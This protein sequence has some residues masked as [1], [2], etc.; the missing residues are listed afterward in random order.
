GRASRILV[1]APASV[2]KQWQVE[3]REKFNLNWPIYDGHML[4]WQATPMQPEGRELPVLRTDWHRQP[5]VIVSSHLL[6][7]QDRFD[8]VVNQAEPWD[9]VVLDEAH[10]ARRKSAANLAEER[11]NALLRLMRDLA[12]RTPGLVLLTATPMQVH[13]VEVWDL[14]ALLGLP[15][16]WHARAFLDFFEQ[17]QHPNPSHETLDQ[18]ARLF[19]AAE[20]RFGSLDPA[21]V[22]RRLEDV[23]VIRLR[24]VLDALRS[25]AGIP[26]RMLSVD[27]RQLALRLARLA[28]PVACLISRHT[29]ALLRRYYER[30]LITTPIASRRVEDRF[31]DMSAGEAALY[32][33]L[34]DYITQTYNQ[35]EQD[36]R[37]ALGFVLTIYRRR[38]AS[39]TRAL[40]LTLEKHLQAVRE[41][42]AA[43]DFFA[44][45]DVEA[46]DSDAEA[47]DDADLDTAKRVALAQEEA[48][49]IEVL[50]R[51]A[52]S[53][54]E[55]TKLGALRVGI[56]EL[57]NSGYAQVM[58][59][60][61]F[62]DTM[63]LLRESLAGR[64]D[65][66]LMCFSGRGGEV[67]TQDGTWRV[68]SRDETKRRFRQGEAHVLLCT[69]AAAEGLN[70]QFCGAL[71]NYDM[72]W[73]P[74]RVEQ[75]IGRIDR[76]GQRFPEI[77][78]LNLHYEDSIEADVYHALGSR[79]D[80][81]QSVVGRLQP[82]LSTL[83]SLIASRVLAGGARGD[84]NRHQVAEDVA[85][86]IDAAEEQNFDLDAIIEDDLAL[87][88]RP[89]PALT[90]R[91]I[92]SLLPRV[93]TLP[94][95]LQ[96]S[97]LGNS[98]W[99]LRMPGMTTP[100][101]VTAD[102]AFFEE[103]AGSVELWSPGSSVFPDPEWA[104]WQ[105]E[106]GA[107]EFPQ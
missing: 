22:Q 55:D 14:L 94:N 71:I 87:P 49:E 26:R 19:V 70:F 104:E 37:S 72:P 45:D 9:L 13:P 103:H 16:G 63:D 89:E 1:M 58:V 42:S 18:I 85:R 28:S 102:P 97:A 84:A 56:D 8:E 100:V 46:L 95:N 11:P 7:R 78:I 3:L 93:E 101:R 5:A 74:M 88:P 59:F 41:G 83:P 79:I 65:L 27:D 50:L 60:T 68:I 44:D 52:R 34:E 76:L 15:D 54:P 33:A 107:P 61:Q 12:P 75:R 43:S 48:S 81:F 39:S 106:Q 40:V 69:D 105:P 20:R 90:L 82:I 6:R 80:L 38:L 4:R 30:G 24:R 99:S 96:V 86:E 23:G 91:Q 73:N 29:R 31:L 66:K 64:D 98:D 62:T 36:E 10:H 35:A 25:D 32:A 92:G 2:C 57:K 77:R 53:L 21:V 47:S 51:L 17:V 67:R